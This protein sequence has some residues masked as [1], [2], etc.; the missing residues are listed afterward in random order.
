[1][2]QSKFCLCPSGYEVA[3]PR[4]VEAIHAGCV[5]VM[6][7]DNY[8]L[9]FNDVLDWSQF[10]VAKI[11]EIKNILEGISRDKYLKMQER[12]IRVQRHFVLNRPAR[13]FDIIHMIL[14]SVWLRS[15]NFE[16][17]VSH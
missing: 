9:S 10:S 11:P 5:P 13:P 16:L 15:L 3:S 14:H 6:I 12:V 8:S 7:S 2:G 4:A 17:P 1:M